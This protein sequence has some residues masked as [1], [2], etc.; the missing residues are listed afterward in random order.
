MKIVIFGASGRI[1]QR[2]SDEALRRGHVVTAAVRDTTKIPPRKNLSSVKADVTVIEDV[3]A[4]VSGQDA[5]VNTTN[6][7]GNAAGD[8]TFLKAARSLLDGLKVAG[9]KRLIVVGGA[10]SLEIAPGKQLV[11]QPDF[12]AGWKPAAL[13]HREALKLYRQDTALDWTYVSPAAFIEPGSRT[14]K[15]HLGTDQ[16][17]TDAKGESRISM[18]DFA[19]AILDELEKPQFIRRRF[20]V[21][22]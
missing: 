5:V 9:V 12:P 17:V 3:T 13:A 11:D 14:G 20:T 19:V 16:L 18:E 4:A 2:I 22:Y 7:A 10:G 1:G 15:F 6:S 8:A 21:A